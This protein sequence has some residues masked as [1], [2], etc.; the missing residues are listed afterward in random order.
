[1]NDEYHPAKCKLILSNLYPILCVC[2]GGGFQSYAT[3]III[4]IK[5]FNPG[6][7]APHPFIAS[8]HR[9]MVFSLR[10]TFTIKNGL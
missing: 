9:Y 3:E 10:D 1:M 7:M 4:E 5:Q 6:R 8:N 2:G